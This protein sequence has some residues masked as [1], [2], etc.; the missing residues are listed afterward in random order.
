MVARYMPTD[1]PED[2]PARFRLYG[3]G[4]GKTGTVSLSGMFGVHWRS[5]HEPDWQEIIRAGLHPDAMRNGD[6]LM[7]PELERIVRA[8][9][10]EMNSSTLNYHLMPLIGRVHPD[11]RFVL[12]VRDPVAWVA[13]MCRHESDKP[14]RTHWDW[15]EIR[16]MRFRPDLYRHRKSDMALARLGLFS[17][18]GY[19]RYYARHNA[20]V[21][22]HVPAG[23][24]LVVGVEQLSLRAT[25]ARLA[26]FAGIPADRIA[27]ERSRMHFS[28]SRFDLFAHVPRDVVEAAAAEYCGEVWAAL[29][30][31]AGI[32]ETAR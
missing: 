7:S 10:W 24:L 16:R 17:L 4:L 3:V 19:L 9:P 31:R 8:W 12:T 21:L 15:W 14:R 6:Y 2:A 18:E 22:A 29:R 28:E 1:Y 32:P 25:V 26:A 23:R 5:A 11:A 30:R 27:R 13:S 20:R